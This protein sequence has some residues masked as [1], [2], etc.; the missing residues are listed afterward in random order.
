M[1]YTKEEL[2]NQQIIV[3]CENQDE[4]DRVVNWFGEKV[5]SEYNSV[6]MYFKAYYILD[7]PDFVPLNLIK[8]VATDS[9]IITAKELFEES[10]EKLD[11]LIQELQV[12]RSYDIEEVNVIRI[13][14]KLQAIKK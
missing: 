9:I 7:N 6:N 8:E 14:N 4:A 13:L 1:K 11:S 2:K 12:L 5:D 3:K 10:E